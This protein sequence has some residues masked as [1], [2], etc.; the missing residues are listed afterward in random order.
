VSRTELVQAFAGFPDRLGA[1]ARAAAGRPVPA[2]EWGPAE[3]VRHLIAA[4]AEVWQPR[5]AR[6]AA[7]PTA[8]VPAVASS[9]LTNNRNAPTEPITRPV[10]GLSSCQR[11]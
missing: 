5:L 1:G 4:E 10:Q 9:V 6:V 2:G 11:L 8:V 3:V 7:D